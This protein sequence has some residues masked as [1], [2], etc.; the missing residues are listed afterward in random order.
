MWL[1]SHPDFGSGSQCPLSAWA[2]TV[3]HPLFPYPSTRYRGQWPVSVTGLSFIFL[4]RLRS[5]E[6]NKYIF[7]FHVKIPFWLNDPKC[8]CSAWKQPIRLQL[9]C[10]H[11]IWRV[12]FGWKPVMEI[13]SSSRVG[14]TCSSSPSLD[15]SCNDLRTTRGPSAMYGRYVCPSPR[16]AHCSD[17]DSGPLIPGLLWRILYMSSPHPWMTLCTCTC[18]KRKAVIHT[19]RAA[20]T[21]ST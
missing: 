12:R 16:A 9:S 7:S 14:R 21:W 13:W 11:F 8:V 5:H 4:T 2:V 15:T 20:V 3:H 10:C 18:G 1:D 17:C 19:S 6:S